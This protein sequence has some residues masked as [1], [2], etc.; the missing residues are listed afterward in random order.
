MIYRNFS[1]LVRPKKYIYFG[2]AALIIREDKLPSY[3]QPKSAL[4][5]RGKFDHYRT[6]LETKK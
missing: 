6:K 2:H 3:H 5:I 4:I 1:N